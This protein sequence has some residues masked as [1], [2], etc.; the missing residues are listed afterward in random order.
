MKILLSICIQLLSKLLSLNSRLICYRSLRCIVA[1]R[2]IL[3]CS[4]CQ[5]NAHRLKPQIKKG[6]SSFFEGSLVVPIPENNQD[7]INAILVFFLKQ[8]ITISL[9]MPNCKYIYTDLTRICRI[10]F[11]S[12]N[13]KYLGL[14]PYL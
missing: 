9:C 2:K 11:L 12:S 6:T 5:D 14:L 3:L 4:G 13:I 1:H 8:N 10:V 7:I